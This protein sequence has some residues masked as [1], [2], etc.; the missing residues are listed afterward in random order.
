MERLRQPDA[1]GVQRDLVAE[2]LR[3]PA[4]ALLAAET[5][6]GGIWLANSGGE[7]RVLVDVDRDA[8]AYEQITGD[9]LIM[10]RSWSASPR[11]WLEA[12]WDGAFPDA[13]FQLH[14]QFRS[15]R[16][17]D[18]LVIAREGYDFRA[19]YEVPEHKA[20]HGSLIRGHMQTPVWSSL[21]LPE[22][23]L[24]TVDLFPSML[25]W[26]GAPIPPGIDGELIWQPGV[27]PA[28]IPA[29]V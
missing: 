22:A 12:T 13:P 26:L 11:E 24:R 10:G 21:P 8:M 6:H 18:L 20:G 9:P 2:L 1:F 25:S 27:E 14:D 28:P 5:R 17:G 23:P 15:H 19:R 4:V 16:S 3:E 29:M 7:A